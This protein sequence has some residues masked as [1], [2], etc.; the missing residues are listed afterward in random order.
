MEILTI[1]LIIDLILGDPYWFYHPVR[2]IGKFI[3][4]EEKL[5]RKF[6][7]TDKDLLTA[8]IALT[9]DTVLV[10]VLIS[11]AVI[12]I[13]TLIAPVLGFIIKVFIVYTALSVKSLKYEGM[14]VKKWLAESLDKGR[15]RV[16]YIVGR[17]TTNL[18]QEEIIKATVETV[19]ENTT[20][21]I[22]SPMIFAL[23]LGPVGAMAYKAVSTLDSMVGYR[24]EKYNFLGRFS[25][26][27]D[28][29]FNFLSARLCGALMVIAAFILGFDYKNS[30]KILKRDHSNHKSPNSAWSE[31]AVAGALGIQ[32]GGTHEYF[33]VSVHKPTIGDPVKSVVIENID[34]TIKIMYVTSLMLIIICWMIYSI[35]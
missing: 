29:V 6:F 2:L 34:Q 11:W 22:V 1:A 8:G 16:G 7:R 12:K 23:L 10:T 27:T 18:S 14:Q 26:K 20:D 24:N 17:D 5:I 25:A 31:S 33:G 4:F 28:D 32:L 35:I 15:E 9:I 30:W 3:E 21:G 19:A 13:S